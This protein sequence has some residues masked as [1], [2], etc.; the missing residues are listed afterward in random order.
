MIDVQLLV[1]LFD[2]EI[3]ILNWSE[4][5]FYKTYSYK[6]TYNVIHLDTVYN[7]GFFHKRFVNQL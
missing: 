5:H 6:P 1:W 2:K 4:L 3:C 7:V